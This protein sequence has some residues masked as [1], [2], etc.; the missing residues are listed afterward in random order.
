MITLSEVGGAQKVVYHLAAGLSREGFEVEVACAPG[1]E[2]VEWLGALPCPVRVWEIPV[3]KRE[4]SPLNDMRCLWQLYRLIKKGGY[5]AV[6]CHSSKAGFLGRLAA[7][8]AGVREVYFTAHGWS[9]NEARGR[10]ERLIY[11]WAERLAGALSSAVVCVSENDRRLGVKAGLTA[12]EK[13]TVIYNGLPECPARPGALRRE[14][15]IGPKG[16]DL[17]VGMVAR[18]AH[19]KE[20]LFF[21]EAAKEVAALHPNAYFV[22]I[23]DGPLYRRCREFIENS[24]L[25]GRAFL[26]GARDTAAALMGDLD[27]FV[28]FSR[29]EGLPLT[30][31]EAMQAGVPVVASAVGG[32][33]EMVAE[34]KTGFL[35]GKLGV[36]EAAAAI[37]R[38]LSDPVLRRQMGDAGRRLARE[39]FSYQKMLSAY[40]ELYRAG[41]AGKRRTT[42]KSGVKV[43]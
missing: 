6:H 4:I 32:V 13:L 31:I 29:W 11:G 42:S 22:L 24:G 18:L 19:P 30:V 2:L 33:P 7:R 9:V 38:L 1:G 28:L 34:G 21:L 40:R 27:V 41:A 17:L 23:G 20:P 12:G 43:N 37:S 26:T 36:G 35:T 25:N 16:G 3:M 15:G 14:L 8:L 10:A 39:K 5:D